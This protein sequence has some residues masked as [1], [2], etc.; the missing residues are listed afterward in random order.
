MT[1][2]LGH[3]A[4]DFTAQ[5][6]DESEI[7]LSKLS[8]SKV[9]LYFYPK[10][11]TPG[12]TSEGE[13]FRDQYDAFQHANTLVFGVSKD[14]ISSHQKFREKYRFPFELISDPDETL[15]KLYDVIRL[16][17]LYG[18]EFMGIERSTFLIGV[19]GSLQHI[20]RKVRINNHIHDVL[21]AAKTLD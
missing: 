2:E 4:P 13:G 16:K 8:G 14:S 9:V 5:L 19:D 21:Q 11:N 7:T 3:P 6:S 1:L 20:W 10:D 18:K 15:C 12:C 17:K